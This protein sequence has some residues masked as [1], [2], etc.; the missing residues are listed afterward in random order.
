LEESRRRNKQGGIIGETT[1]F[2]ALRINIVKSNSNNSTS[3]LIA[4]AYFPDSRRETSQYDDT[5]TSIGTRN[6][7]GERLD[8]VAPDY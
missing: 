2:L 6:L 8:D 7:R 5:N 3:L 4:M 1:R